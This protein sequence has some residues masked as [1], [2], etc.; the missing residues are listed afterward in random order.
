MFESYQPGWG[1]FALTRHSTRDGGLKRTRP[2]HVSWNRDTSH[3]C[4]EGLAMLRRR[5]FLTGVAAAL[6]AR[7]QG[8]WPQKPITIVVPFGP[9]GSA[10]LVARIFAQHF[11]AQQ[12]V[13]GVIANK[14]G[15]GG[16]IGHG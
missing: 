10:D 16:R 3:S 15:A 8:V 5:D 4:N 6:S 13:S 1:G 11:Q 2:T 12:G 7:S 9:G 14:G